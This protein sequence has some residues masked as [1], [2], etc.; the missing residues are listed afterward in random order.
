MYEQMKSDVRLK[1]LN[2]IQKF[3]T[4]AAKHYDK[5]RYE[6]LRLKTL[7]ELNEELFGITDSMTDIIS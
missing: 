1:S 2:Y 6:Q 5:G 3:Y 7:K 4:V